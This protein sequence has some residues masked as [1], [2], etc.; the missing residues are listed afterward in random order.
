M[1]LSPALIFGNCYTHIDNPSHNWG[2]FSPLMVPFL[3]RFSRIYFKHLSLLTFYPIVLRA[4]EFTRAE[5]IPQTYVAANS[6]ARIGLTKKKK[7]LYV[8]HVPGFSIVLKI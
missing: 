3:L 8:F 4:S 7:K 1:L 2:R 5:A 6:G